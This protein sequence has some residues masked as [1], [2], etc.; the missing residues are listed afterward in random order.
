MSTLR[1]SYLGYILPNEFEKRYNDKIKWLRR[2]RLC[3][4]MGSHS[5]IEVANGYNTFKLFRSAL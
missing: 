2:I 1:H 4:Q 3:L 5:N